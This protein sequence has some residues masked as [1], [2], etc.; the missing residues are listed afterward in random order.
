MPSEGFDCSGMV[1]SGFRRIG[2]LE[3]NQDKN[4]DALF[5]SMKTQVIQRSAAKAGCLAFW[6]NQENRAVHVA[7]FID[8]HSIIHA[9]GGGSSTLTIEDAMQK[10]AFI[11]IRYF[12]KFATYRKDRF[13]QKYKIVDPFLNTDTPGDPS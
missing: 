4:A 9:S 11:K 7:T 8:R 10:D 13:N 1:T 6:F 5:Q 2:K 12:D 3:E